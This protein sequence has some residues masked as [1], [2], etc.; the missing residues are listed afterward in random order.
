MTIESLIQTYGYVVIFVGTFL[1]GET[2]LVLGGL[3]AHQGYLQLPWVVLAAFAGTLL[4]DQLF[5]YFGR[6]HSHTM[7][8]KHPAWQVRVNKAQRLVERYRTTVI[9]S[10]RFMYG[11]RTVT[12]FVI[13]MS[14]VPTTTFIILNVL[15]ALV[16]ALAIGVGGY[17]FG[18]TLEIIL[19]D[20][21]H[22]ELPILGAI[23]VIGVSLWALHR[24]HYYRNNS[25]DHL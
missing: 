20:I 7:L 10:F 24:Y 1:E 11:L 18:Y 23:V 14:R 2:V 21:K 3:A 19:G 15:S 22:Y 8:T 17:C 6:W 12:P 13:G 16:W 9:I 4:G 25:G 5:F